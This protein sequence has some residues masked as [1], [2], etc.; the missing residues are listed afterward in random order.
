ME[1]KN[2]STKTHPN[3]TNPGPTIIRCSWHCPTRPQDINS[4]IQ[5]SINATCFFSLRVF[6]ETKSSNYGSETKFAH[7]AG[8]FFF[9]L[10][11]TIRSKSKVP[12]KLLQD[13]S[14]LSDAPCRKT[15]ATL[16][17]TCVR[18][19]LYLG[20]AVVFFAVFCC[21]SASDG[22]QYDA[23]TRV[24]RINDF[25][26]VHW[27]SSKMNYKSIY[28]N[29]YTVHQY[30]VKMIRPNITSL[31]SVLTSFRNVSSN[32]DPIRKHCHSHS[33]RPSSWW[34]MWISGQFCCYIMVTAI[35][36]L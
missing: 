36:Q 21:V 8:C 31:H 14:E 23:P 34:V 13:L 22:I 20:I 1:S 2:G 15:I 4:D 3:E 5:D 17:T 19:V 33:P 18:E 11:H 35:D 32:R 7:W 24:K 26:W 12:P 10:S 29:I 30:T 9:T 25:D 6:C 27:R 28:I 16:R